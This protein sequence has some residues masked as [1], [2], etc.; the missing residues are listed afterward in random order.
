MQREMQGADTV[1]LGYTLK[2]LFLDNRLTRSRQCEEVRD[3]YIW[4]ASSSL[5]LSYCVPGRVG[6]N[7]N[8]P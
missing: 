2:Q 8:T 6:I 4:H 1:V 3:A 5:G 7:I